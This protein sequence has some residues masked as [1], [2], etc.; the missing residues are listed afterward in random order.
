[1]SLLVERLLYELEVTM[2]L[3]S[4]ARRVVVVLAASLGLSPL[5][6]G[7]QAG[8]IGHWDGT[9]VREAARLE[10]SFDFAASGAKLEGTFTSLTQQAMDYP[11][12]LVTTNSNKVHFVLGESLVFNGKLRPDEI[13]GTFTDDGAKGDFT[14]HRTTRTRTRTDT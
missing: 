12:A 3:T 13:T 7:S 4:S 2:S 11:L 6:F 1:M 9:M 14:L 10:V 8:L 5:V